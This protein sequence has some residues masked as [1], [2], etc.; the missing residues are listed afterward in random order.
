MEQ[1]R[2]LGRLHGHHRRFRERKAQQLSNENDGRAAAGLCPTAS[3]TQASILAWNMGHLGL[4]LTFQCLRD[5]LKPNTWTLAPA[6]AQAT[7]SWVPASPLRHQGKHEHFC[8]A[9]TD[10]RCDATCNSTAWPDGMPTSRQ[11]AAVRT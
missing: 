9:L 5:Q 4:L 6:G 11:E 1:V 3:P 7:A 10:V 8:W 2:R